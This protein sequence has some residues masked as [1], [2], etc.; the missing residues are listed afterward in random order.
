MICFLCIASLTVT[1]ALSEAQTQIIAVDTTADSLDFVAPQTVAQLPG[2]DGKVS[3]REALTAANKT[4]GPQTITFRIPVADPGFS[5]GVFTIQPAA[6]L[7]KLTDHGTTVDGAT[8]TAFSGDTNPYGPEIVLDGSL[9]G[10]TAFWI[11]ESNDHVI[12]GLVI[13]N[14]SFNAIQFYQGSIPPKRTRIVGC[15][16]GTDP[17]GT[18][19]SG[20]FQAIAVNGEDHVIGGFGPGEG[21]L[22]A[23]SSWEEIR[24]CSDFAEIECA[25]TI[26]VGNRIGTDRTGTRSLSFGSQAINIQR[27]SGA[28][29]QGNFI[30]RIPGGAGIN[31]NGPYVVGTVVGGTTPAHGNT[32]AHNSGPGILVQNGATATISGNEI[33]GNQDLGIDIDETGPNPNDPGDLDTGSNG[34]M[35][36][37]VLTSVLATPGQLIVSGI[38]DTVDSRSVVLE[39]FATPPEL[40]HASG[41]GGARHFLGTARPNLSGKFRATL[42]PVA[43]GT[44][45]TATATGPTGTSEFSEN[46]VAEARE[47]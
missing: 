33:Y 3:Y 20:G 40:A 24:V 42:P 14:F 21:N 37:P 30:A 15:Y 10:G 29:I 11:E 26:I 38:I 16:L 41:H 9:A 47:K 36:Y 5:D 43:P 45:I 22:I 17:T 8:Q 31:I 39:F 12:R 1:S 7:P 6:P 44:F 4:P 18:I 34:R 25:R 35:N 32:I 2:P 28:V 13:R 19:A 27:S 23:G 46:H